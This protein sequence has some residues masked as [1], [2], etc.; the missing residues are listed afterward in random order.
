MAPPHQKSLPTPPHYTL[1]QVTLILDEISK[2]ILKQAI[3][4]TGHPSRRDFYS[5]IFLVPKKDGGQRLV[6]NLKA[7]N[8]FIHTE[9]GGNPYS[10]R[11]AGTGGLV[12]KGRPQ[13]RILCDSHS[14]ITS[15]VSKIS[16]SRESLPLHLS[17]LRSVLCPV[18]IHQDFEASPVHAS[19]EGSAGDR[20]HRRHPDHSRV[21][22]PSH[23][24]HTSPGIPTRMPGVH[25]Q[26]REVCTYTRPDHR[27]SGSHC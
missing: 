19:T 11:H 4:I 14:P 17:S 10:E 13:R 8:S 21:Q 24:A 6:I 25:Y 7:L 9:H 1:E 20:L 5:N 22:E 15:K 23:R 2:L 18:D 3:K 12:N 27:V 16:V 26:Y